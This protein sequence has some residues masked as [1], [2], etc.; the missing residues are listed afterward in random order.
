M[1]P[2]GVTKRNS[3]TPSMT[4]LLV[5]EYVLKYDGLSYVLRLVHS[6]GGRSIWIVAMLDLVLAPIFDPL[7]YVGSFQNHNT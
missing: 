2:A 1:S 6:F 7:K 3:V 4:P 5:I